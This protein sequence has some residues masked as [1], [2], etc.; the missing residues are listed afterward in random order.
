MKP[1][2]IKIK[3]VYNVGLFIE[4]QMASQTD[5]LLLIFCIFPCFL[6]TILIPSKNIQGRG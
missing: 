5:I 4:Q 1:K 3:P 6:K 2:S